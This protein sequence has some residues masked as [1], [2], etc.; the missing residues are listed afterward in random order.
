MLANIDS[1]INNMNP[2]GLT[3]Q[4]KYYNI[5]LEFKKTVVLN[6]NKSILHTIVCSSIN[7]LNDFI[8]YY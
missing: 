7:K 8:Y 2:N 1:D 6:K 3:N 5:S 4:C